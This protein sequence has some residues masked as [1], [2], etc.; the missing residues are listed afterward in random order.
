MSGSWYAHQHVQS[1]HTGVSPVHVHAAI[2]VHCQ[3][4]KE[5]PSHGCHLVYIIHAFL[6]YLFIKFLLYVFLQG[7]ST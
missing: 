3:N 2:A 6:V 7:C 4:P 5:P 1:P